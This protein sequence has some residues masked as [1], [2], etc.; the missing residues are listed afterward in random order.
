MR[1]VTRADFD[2]LICG[3][4]LKEAGIIDNILFVHPKDVQ[5]GKVEVTAD[6]VLANVPYAKGCGMWFDH[7]MSELERKAFPAD[8]KG[9][10]SPE[11]SCARVIYKHYGG[12]D[13]FPRFTEMMT[14]VDKSDSGDLSIEEVAEPRG[15]L[16]LAVVMD[17]RTGLGRYSDYRISNLQ[18]MQDLMESC[19]TMP[20]E[21]ILEQPDVK[22]RVKRYHESEWMYKEMIKGHSRVEDKVLVVDLRQ[23][24]EIPSGNRF[25][26]YGMFPNINISIRVMWGLKK[27]NV[28]FA[29][30]HSIINR[31]SQTKVG[32]LMLKYGGGGHDKVGTCQVPAEKA[33][34]VLAELVKQIKADG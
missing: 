15:W 4:L 6:D 22:E 25:V 26:E 27:Q 10:S 21:E 31:T 5:D 3:V 34:E 30:G 19:R 23:M 1:L 18:L 2:G 9:W 13:K 20:I 11:K 17:P 16:L 8:Y 7:H 24:E 33:E 29:V 14:A 12:A 28:V 32:S